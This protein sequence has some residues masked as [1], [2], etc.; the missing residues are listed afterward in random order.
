MRNRTRPQVVYSTGEEAATFH[1]LLAGT[2]HAHGGGDNGRA[3]SEVRGEGSGA[4]RWGGRF[5][6]G[7]QC[8]WRFSNVGGVLVLFNSFEYFDNVSVFDQ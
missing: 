2:A 4:F 3:A 1:L 7:Q 8:G 6:F 5:S